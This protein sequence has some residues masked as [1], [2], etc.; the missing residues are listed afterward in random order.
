MHVLAGDGAGGFTFHSSLV[1]DMSTAWG[2]VSL[3]ALDFDGD[4]ARDIVGT[5]LDDQPTLLHNDGTGQF[6]STHVFF[7]PPPGAANFTA[8]QFDGVGPLDI[9]VSTAGTTAVYVGVAEPPAEIFPEDGGILPPSVFGGQFHLDAWNDGTDPV[10]ILVGGFRRPAATLVQNARNG[11]AG[12]AVVPLAG[13]IA[14]LADVH[15]DGNSDLVLV[16][17]DLLWV[18]GIPPGLGGVAFDCYG[19]APNDLD[20]PLLRTVG[21]FDGN[22]LED[23]AISDETEVVVYLAF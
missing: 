21:D 9:M 20:N 22:G 17:D 4:G 7:T 6:D 1:A 2:E 23:L 3:V 18:T 8:G 10:D 15:G 11:V 19:V 13:S 5:G 14:G 12:A 16:G